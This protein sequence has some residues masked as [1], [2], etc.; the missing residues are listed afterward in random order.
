MPA[1]PQ[2]RFLSLLKKDI[3]KLDL[4]E[5]DFGVYRVLAH[6][7]AE[8]ERFFDDTLPAAIAEALASGGAD[9]TAQLDERLR[10]LRDELTGFAQG[11]G[12]ASAFGDGETLVETLRATPKGQEY[13]ALAQERAEAA[14]GA[15][16]A[17]TQEATVFGHLYTFFS[18]YY[19]DGDFQAQPRRGRQAQYSVPY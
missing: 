12:L 5:L 16:F 8:I 9:R 6:R 13:A 19:R 3:L 17:D 15:G 4:A 14:A 7:R 10:V 18:R 1:D 2:T 11:L